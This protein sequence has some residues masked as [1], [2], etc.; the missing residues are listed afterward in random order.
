[1]QEKQALQDEADLYALVDKHLKYL[2]L[3]LA[4]TEIGDDEEGPSTLHPPDM[5]LVAKFMNNALETATREAVRTV[6]DREIDHFERVLEDEFRDGE[7]KQ[8]REISEFLPALEKKVERLCGDKL[9]ITHVKDIMRDY[10]RLVH[11]STF[12]EAYKRAHPE[13]QRY[14]CD[15][16]EVSEGSL[17]T[18]YRE[19]LQEQRVD[20]KLLGD[21]I[22]WN[23]RISTGQE[24]LPYRFG[25]TSAILNDELDSID[26]PRLL[27]L[28]E[29]QEEMSA[30]GV[31]D[32][33]D[34]RPS[35]NDWALAQSQMQYTYFK[36]MSGSDSSMTR[37]IQPIYDFVES[38]R[39][40]A[41]SKDGASSKDQAEEEAMQKGALR[42]TIAKML[43][44]MSMRFVLT[45]DEM[46]E[47]VAP[48]TL[49]PVM[50]GLLKEPMSPT[51]RLDVI[52][53]R[54]ALRLLEKLR[55]QGADFIQELGLESFM[56]A[57]PVSSRDD[58][59]V[60]AEPSDDRTD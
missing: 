45:H 37:R 15:P 29:L 12:S 27:S 4:F 22:K 31:T 21:A 17:L 16:Q 40:A 34:Q 47:K 44:Y 26:L 38:K 7:G 30:A 11:S 10:E 58:K 59:G 19:W 52:M 2:N 3:G 55:Q 54:E 35:Q 23:P 39:E 5:P 1:V 42:K 14:A 25:L 49:D 8:V 28:N 33:L 20:K 18:D 60:T 32:N 41:S 56:M 51:S 6:V 53:G 57:P 46:G 48:P 9:Q 50:E 24:S 13:D 43:G 36:A